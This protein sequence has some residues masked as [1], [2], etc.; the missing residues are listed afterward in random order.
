VIGTQREDEIRRFFERYGQVIST[1][2]LGAVMDFW[3][4]PALVLSDQGAAAVS[5]AAEIERF[6]TQALEWYRSRGLVTTRPE[7]ERVEQLSDK[8]TSVDVRWP[9]YDEDGVEKWS[10]RSHYILSTGNDG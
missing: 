2:D 5:D 3:E 9:T 6:F 8:N 4:V 7:I 10:E 1:G